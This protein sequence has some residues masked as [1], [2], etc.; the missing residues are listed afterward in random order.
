MIKLAWLEFEW[1]PVSAVVVES[2]I[3]VIVRECRGEYLYLLATGGSFAR[4][5][6]I[7]ML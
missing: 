3:T 2:V 7:M 6:Q 5:H 1:I 4:T